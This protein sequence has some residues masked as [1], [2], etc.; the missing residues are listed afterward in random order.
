MSMDDVLP[1]FLFVI[2]RA[3][4]HHLGAEVRFLEDFL[5]HA[6]LSGESQVLL[7]TIKAAYFQLQR[8]APD[9][10]P[11][12]VRCTPGARLVFLYF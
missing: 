9:A 3:H 12:P 11:M 2:V 8:E 4:V 10:H 5:D 7:T 1:V 6:L